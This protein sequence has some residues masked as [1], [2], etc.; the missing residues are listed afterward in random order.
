M[1]RSSR[2]F[3]ERIVGPGTWDRISSELR[4]QYEGEGHVLRLD[5]EVG[6]SGELFDPHDIRSPVLM[7]FG[8]E[9]TAHHQRGV[10]WFAEQIPTAEI[11]SF[12]GAAHGAHR[13]H[14]DAFAEFVSD[15]DRLA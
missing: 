10:E 11:R 9:T 5:L 8:Q 3:H 4:S 14:P 2:S 12:P 7:G 6:R 15:V 1:S 13:S